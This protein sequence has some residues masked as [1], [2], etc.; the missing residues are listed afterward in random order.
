MWIEKQRNVMD[1]ALSS[2]WRRK[3]KNAA[4]MGAY[5]LI[6]F[7]LSSVMFFTHSI[8]QEALLL[9]REAPE[10][11]VQRLVAGRH[12]LIPSSYMESLKK[13]KGV[14][15]VRGRLWGYYYDPTM[16]Q[17]IPSSLTK[18]STIAPVM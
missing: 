1:F 8:K 7:L 14:Q 18:R 6:V 9:L 17:T 5:T 13:I 11:M 16:A 12:D 2:L 10:M 3:G 15:E 4:L